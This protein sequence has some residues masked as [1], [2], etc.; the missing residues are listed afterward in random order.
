MLA[1]SRSPIIERDAGRTGECR[2]VTPTAPGDACRAQG[3]HA[4]AVGQELVVDGGEGVEDQAV[5]RGVDAE[6][7][8]VEG[9]GDRFVERDPLGDAVAEALGRPP[10]VLGEA[11]RRGPVQPAAA[12]FQRQRSVPVVQGGHGGDA[13]FQQLVDQPVVEVE[14]LAVE[15]AACRPA[16][17]AAR[18]G[19]SGRSRCRASA[20]ARR[21]PAAGCSG[22]RRRRGSGRPWMAAGLFGK[23]V[24][25]GGPAAAGGE[26]SFDLECRR[27]DAQR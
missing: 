27:G 18:R 8:A 24:P 4:E 9:D 11:F 12:V 3:L 14:A 15:R 26:G 23:G 6:G 19:R 22:R 7:V 5:A 13:G 10:R 21:P 17:S 2:L 16:G 25:A 1:R 20:S